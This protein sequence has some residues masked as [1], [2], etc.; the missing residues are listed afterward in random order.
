MM[1]GSIYSVRPSPLVRFEVPHTACCTIRG[2]RGR[3]WGLLCILLLGQFTTPLNANLQI[4]SSL[5]HSYTSSSSSSS[6][7]G[8]PTPSF[9]YSSPLTSSPAHLAHL[10]PPLQPTHSGLQT[11]FSSSLS[12]KRRLV[13]GLT[14]LEF[15]FFVFSLAIFRSLDISPDED[16]QAQYQYLF[17]ILWS[18]SS[19]V[20]LTELSLRHKRKGN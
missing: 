14:V 10:P 13:T 19:G 17:L 11:S 16:I 12:P 4:A 3:I 8:F 1:E 7:V 9:E 6:S 5:D 2:K 18:V 15:L 20:W